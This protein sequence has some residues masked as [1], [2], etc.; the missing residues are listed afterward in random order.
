MNFLDSGEDQ[1]SQFPL[2]IQQLVEQITIAFEK[3]DQLELQFEGRLQKEKRMKKRNIQE[4][5][6]LRTDIENTQ[7]N[8]LEAVKGLVQKLQTQS[9]DS[10]ISMNDSQYNNLQV[11]LSRYR[12]M[13]SGKQQSLNNLAQDV[14]KVIIQSDATQ[15][16]DASDD[17]EEVDPKE[18]ERQTLIDN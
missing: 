16:P 6:D 7:L 9:Q 8:D 17:Q 11:V 4:L 18:Q 14:G 12:S 1:S 3:I 5:N 15:N 10:L 2:Q 13:V